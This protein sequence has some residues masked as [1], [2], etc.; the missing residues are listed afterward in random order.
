MGGGLGRRKAHLMRRGRLSRQPSRDNSHGLATVRATTVASRKARSRW[1]AAERRRGATRSVGQGHLC[2][3]PLEVRP[4]PADRRKA[5]GAASHGPAGR[6]PSPRP[7]RPQ[8]CWWRSGG[9]SPGAHAVRRGKPG[10][11]KRSADRRPGRSPRRVQRRG[12]SGFPARGVARE[13]AERKAWG[14]PFFG[15]RATSRSPSSRAFVQKAERLRWT[16]AAS[17]PFVPPVRPPSKWRTNRGN[18]AIRVIN[19]T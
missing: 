8:G 6:R 11:V 17:R 14:A 15:T 4:P 18:V 7:K 2:P 19:T 3:Q 16:L 5:G 10:R 9:R 12:L 1:A 13:S